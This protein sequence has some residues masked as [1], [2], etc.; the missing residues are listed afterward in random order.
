MILDESTLSPFQAVGRDMFLTGLVSSHSGTMSVQIDGKVSL[1]RR[2]AML[3]RLAASDF[4][5]LPLEGEPPE[6]APEDVLV[7]RAIYRATQAQAVIH[8]RPPATM[9]LAL[10]DD[11]LAPANGEGADAFGTVPVAISQRAFGS[12]EVA[13]LMGQMLR[14]SRVAVLRGRGV[15]AWGDDLDG[16]LHMVSLLEEMCRVTCWFRAMSHEDEQPLVP[17]R[18]ERGASSLSPY[19]T[20]RDGNSRQPMRHGNAP[21]RPGGGPPPRRDGNAHRQ[22]GPQGGFRP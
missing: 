14:E 13:D 8:A 6:G 17:D 18:Q 22:G 15:F 5:E 20:T 10:I 21:R 12:V 19:R 16:A 7:H 9:A 1:T 11:R 2:G 4:V 3:G